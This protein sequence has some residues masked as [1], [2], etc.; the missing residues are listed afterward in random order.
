VSVGEFVQKYPTLRFVKYSVIALLVQW[1]LIVLYI[2]LSFAL[3]RRDVYWFEEPLLWAYLWPLLVL[4][5]GHSHGGEFFFM[6][7][8][9]ILYAGIFG[10]VMAIRKRPR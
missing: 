10:V 6:P 3:D 1:A 4:P 5:R 8:T 7:I 2:W 9:A